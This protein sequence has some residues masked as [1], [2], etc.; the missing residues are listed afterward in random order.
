METWEIRTRC[1][2]ISTHSKNR[3]DVID[4]AENQVIDRVYKTEWG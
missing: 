3:T 4:V 2:M 1:K